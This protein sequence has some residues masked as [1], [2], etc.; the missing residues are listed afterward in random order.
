MKLFK[1]QRIDI[2]LIKSLLKKQNWY[3]RMDYLNDP[4]DAFLIDKTNNK[5][6]EILRSKLYVSSYSQNRNEIL[7]WSHYADSH[8]G[9]CLE[10]EIDDTKNQFYKA[11]FEIDYVDEIKELENIETDDNGALKMSINSNGKF[12]KT[13]FK[14]WSYEEETRAYLSIDGSVLPGIYKDFLGPLKKIYFGMHATNDD[15]ETIKLCTQDY[16]DLEY[17]KVSLDP[18]SLKMDKLEKV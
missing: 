9:L 3:S 15:I 14:T 7:M 8:K 16:M 13:K 11:L 10:W 12:L 1:Y 17:L 5:T 18:E 4:F 2:N 6:Y